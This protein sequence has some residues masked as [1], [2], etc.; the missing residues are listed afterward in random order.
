MTSIPMAMKTQT[1]N[2]RSRTS[3]QR[4]RLPFVS[5]K[6]EL[7]PVIWVPTRVFFTTGVG[8]HEVQRVAIQDAMAKAG[9]A[10]CNLVKTSSV[11]PPACEI[12]SRQRGERLLREG[13]ITHAVIAQG[14]TNEPHQRVTAALCWAHSDNPLIPG[15]ITEIEEQETMGKSTTTA[16]DEAGEALLTI[17]GNRLGASVD[18]ESLWSKRGRS[19]SVRIGRETFR[20]GSVT[21]TAIGAEG[22]EPQ[23]SVAL[24]L[25]IFL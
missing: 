10:D 25:A 9:V 7:P 1:G 11:I 3:N 14:H 13:G 4:Q 24:A 6:R 12:I 17:I 16:S 22:S 21:A 2:G 5:E 19:R 18:A 23:H 20:V 15:Y 8:R